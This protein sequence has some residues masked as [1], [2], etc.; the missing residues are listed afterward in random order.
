MKYSYELKIFSVIMLSTLLIFSSSHFGV[1]AFEGIVSKTKGFP[2]NTWIGPI[3]VSGLEKTESSQLLASK[4]TEWQASSAVQLS[5]KEVNVTLPFEGIDFKLEESVQVAKDS[6]KNEILIDIEASSVQAT[7]TS[8]SPTLSE[9]KVNVDML[10]KD[11]I[12]KV[13]L[14][15]SGIITINVEDYLSVAVNE[16]QIVH[17]V[18]MPIINDDLKNIGA[19]ITIEPKDTF[20]LLSFLEKQGLMEVDIRIIDLVSSGIYQAIL[21]TNFEILER[22]ISTE[23]P[24]YISLGFEA[25]VDSNLKW[26]LA[27]YNPTEDEYKVEIYSDG[28]LLIFDV[29]GVPFLNEYTIMQEGI[30]LF[31]PKIIKQYSPLLQPGQFQISKNGK[32]GSYIEISRLIIDDTGKIVEQQLISK[33]YYA[34]VHQVRVVGLGTK[35][36]PILNEDKNTDVIP[37]EA[38][39]EVTEP[40]E[41]PVDT[42]DPNIGKDNLEQDPIWGRPDDNAK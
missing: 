2:E 14:L 24:E 13:S 5:Y 18:K 7:L 1:L 34:P 17:T 41:I 31:D 30:K 6:I 12:T 20:S 21:P 39:S 15:Q 16:A 28:Q 38:P 19:T 10:N 9:N 4:V 37:G 40:I 22:H 33:D 29:V 35:E 25:K 8:L 32:K 27:F 42:A 26:D 11:I 23:L 3:D 36:S